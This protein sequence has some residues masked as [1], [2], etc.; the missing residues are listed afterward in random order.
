VAF[1]VGRVP[2][3]RDGTALAHFGFADSLFLAK[4]R[5]PPLITA[6]GYDVRAESWFSLAG[7]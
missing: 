2:S 1:F 6:G 3:S 4:S 5:R 7:S